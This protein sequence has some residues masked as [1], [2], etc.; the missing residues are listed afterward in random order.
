MNKTKKLNKINGYSKTKSLLKNI[1]NDVQN[2]CSLPI[3]IKI[4]TNE[5]KI[6][7]I[8]LSQTRN[9]R[10]YFIFLASFLLYSGLKE[11]HSEHQIS[12]QISSL[13]K[14]AYRNKDWNRNIL[15]IMWISTSPS[16]L[17]SLS[18]CRQN[19]HVDLHFEICIYTHTPSI[20]I[21]NCR[22]GAAG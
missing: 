1:N 22:D 17:T 11:N 5:L 18:E 12:H 21:S 20:L 7:I 10:L 13:D 14:P 4:A 9:R 16:E 8:I 2:W 3:K 19:I 6:K 15:F